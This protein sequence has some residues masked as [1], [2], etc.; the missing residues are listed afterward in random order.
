MKLERHAS[1]VK[2]AGLILVASISVGQIAWATES[3]EQAIHDAY[4]GWVKAANEKDIEK[5]STFLADDPYFDPAD[6][7]P[8]TTTQE[9]TEYYERSFAD[10]WFSLDCKQETI[11]VFDSGD[12]AWAHGVCFA[13]FTGP[14]G[15]K[16]SGK[17]RW[18]KVWVKHSDGSWRGRVNMW[19]Y[20]N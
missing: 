14:D 10:A 12:T 1:V 9:V 4:R 2:M 11:D 6:S 19:Q 17:S 20:I 3:E 5:W 15:E 16:A 18:F 13:T 7:P 8:L